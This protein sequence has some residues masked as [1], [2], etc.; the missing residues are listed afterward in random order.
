[1][2]DFRA[3]ADEAREHGVAL[4]SIDDNIDL[5]S[6]SGT[7]F[8]TVMAAFSEMEAA[9]I[10][11]RVLEGIERVKAV[12]RYAGGNNL[13][14]GYRSAPAPT[15][16]GRILVP[17]AD[18]ATLAGEMA[19]RVLSG[20]SLYAITQSLN[21]RGIPSK[22]GK[23]WSIQAVRQVVTGPAIVGRVTHRGE[24]V[25]GDDG[26][27]L[28]AFEPVLSVET[29]RAV[30]TALGAD[31]PATERPKRVRAARLLSGLV[32]CGRCFAP[33]YP[34]TS[35][36][37]KSY[38][39]STASRGQDCVGVS[40]RCEAL[41]EHVTEKFLRAYGRL[42]VREVITT[43]PPEPAELI[44]IEHAIQETTD[45]MR[46]AEDLAPLLERLAVLKAKRDDLRTAPAEPTTEVIDTGRTFADTWADAEGDVARQRALLSD[47]VEAIL[48]APG[49]AGRRPFA[50]ERVTIVP[51]E[52]RNVDAEDGESRGPADPSM[53]ARLGLPPLTEEAGTDAA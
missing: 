10:R 40:V 42:P 29:W 1:V 16:G 51:A 23:A 36:G 39:C 21:A 34:A 43:T 6:A 13:P 35:G 38:R 22:K 53:R 28:Q 31:Q 3:I 27:P 30:R 37:G 20:E 19:E 8:A 46:D 15:G 12:G 4:V 44:E 41:E 26:L 18:E 17:V 49:K 47:G 2:T 33:M 48:V 14:F 25:R 32:T 24:V 9:T 5:T 11:Q 50:V 7:F 52:G 45:A